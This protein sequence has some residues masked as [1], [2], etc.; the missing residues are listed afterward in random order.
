MFHANP[1]DICDLDALHPLLMTARIR[2]LWY[3][4]F[5]A[6]Q[7]QDTNQTA[8]L[9]TVIEATLYGKVFAILG[10]PVSKLQ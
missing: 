9:A 4:S 8:W 10:P 6:A 7:L 1:C 3:R 5:E 2:A